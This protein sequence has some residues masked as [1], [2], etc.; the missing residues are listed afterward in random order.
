M[1]SV[2]EDM[3]LKERSCIAGANA[4]W[5]NLSGNQFGSL[6]VINIELTY[7][8]VIPLLGMYV[9]KRSGN[10]RPWKDL[11]PNVLSSFICNSPKLESVQ[12]SFNR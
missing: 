11:S 3:K 12:M 8:P 2:G 10:T 1:T 9:P 7:D 5:Y 4:K 6:F